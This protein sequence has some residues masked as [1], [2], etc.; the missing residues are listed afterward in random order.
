MRGTGH[1]AEEPALVL[2][3]AQARTTLDQVVAYPQ[4]FRAWQLTIEK[5]VDARDYLIA[6][7]ACALLLRERAHVNVLAGGVRSWLGSLQRVHVAER[8]L[9][10]MV[11][12]AVVAGISLCLGNWV[13]VGRGGKPPPQPTRAYR[14]THYQDMSGAACSHG[15]G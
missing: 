5:I 11:E 14:A 2:E 9:G 7:P 10:R 13:P 1:A 8:L 12:A 4:V 15:V 3:P 6:P